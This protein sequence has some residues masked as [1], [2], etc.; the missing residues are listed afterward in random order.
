MISK[1]Y[2]MNCKTNIISNKK[3]TWEIKTINY[4]NIKI[5]IQNILDKQNLIFWP[6]ISFNF[7]NFKILIKIQLMIIK[8]K[9]L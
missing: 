2:N 3:V 5:F 1:T 9:K 6:K 4:F 8:Q 7:N